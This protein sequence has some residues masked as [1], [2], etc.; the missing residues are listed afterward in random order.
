[1]EAVGRLAGGIAHEFNNI[2][3]SIGL[4][5]ELAL[6]SSPGKAV[7]SKLLDIMKQA[8]RAADITRH[9]LAFSRRQVLQPKVVNIND[10]IRQALP[11]VQRIMGA[12]IDLQLKLDETLD[13]V[14]VDPEQ[15]EIVLGQLAH[16][17]RAAMPQGGSLRIATADASDH[18][19]AN[20]ALI[21]VSDS[22]AGMDR[23]TL[24]RVFEPFFSSRDITVL[25]G[26]G[27]ST[28][29]GII[30]Q[31]NGRIECDSAPGH[32]TTFRIFL[33]L[34]SHEAAE[35]ASVQ[36]GKDCGG[37]H[38]L[39]A[40]DDASVN[41]YLTYALRNVG[42][43]V[44]SVRDGRKALEAL[45][46]GSYQLLITDILMPHMGGIELV[47]QARKRLPELP[48]VLISGFTEEPAVLQK[49]PPDKIAYLQKPFPYA[50][51]LETMS[52]LLNPAG[53]RNGA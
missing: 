9:L 11:M 15:L 43:T 42:F 12:D 36:G 5:C 6:Q 18:K 29:Y 17:A 2:T 40:E 26:L 49:L 8:E 52:R 14:F 39:L 19:A 16:N 21:T 31:S 48:M 22:G 41:K 33:P 35:P 28:V 34:A 46:R 4:S 30:T 47:Q 50:K 38:V 37:A 25:T 7:E 45:E 44:E 13:C 27:L 20:Y 24:Q 3:Q 23:A 51:L 53:H 32:G 1:M 10:C